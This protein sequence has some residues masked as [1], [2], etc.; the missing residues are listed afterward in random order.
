[1]EHK[2][3]ILE[4]KTCACASSKIRH[5]FCT[6][7]IVPISRAEFLL[8]SLENILS[9][10]NETFSICELCRSVENYAYDVQDYLIIDFQNQECTLKLG[11]IQTNIDI[12]HRIFTLV[13]VIEEIISPISG[14]RHFVAYC[15]NI[16]NRWKKRDNVSKRS[17]S[18]S[19]KTSVI[20][21]LILYV[22]KK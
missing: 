17:E 20:T 2:H 12:G 14:A 21:A 9:K 18:A 4:E 11:Q 6:S 16:S 15:K 5:H 3:S 13:G 19:E 1:M 8:Q 10:K 7:S 22:Q